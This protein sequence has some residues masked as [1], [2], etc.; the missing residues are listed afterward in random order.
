MSTPEV[1]LTPAQQLAERITR[2]FV[3]E[4]LLTSDLAHDIQAQV[5][6]GK[7]QPSDWKLTFE[8]ALELHKRNEEGSCLRSWKSL[9]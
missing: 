2:R 3:D 8:K 4:G 5:A 9:P 7:M 1:S 6:D